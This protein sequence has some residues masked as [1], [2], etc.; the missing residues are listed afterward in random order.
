VASIIGVPVLYWVHVTVEVVIAM[1]EKAAVI[2]HG[3]MLT[4]WNLW[5]FSFISEFLL[6]IMLVRL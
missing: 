5:K 6:C 4:M 1:M 2:G 3:L